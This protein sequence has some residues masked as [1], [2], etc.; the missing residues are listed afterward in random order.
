M[1]TTTLNIHPAAP[2]ADE[3]Q[4]LGRHLRQCREARGRWFATASWVERAHGLIAPRLFTTVL[5]ATALLAL[6]RWWT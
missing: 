2:L 4:A 3:L 5:G 6:C 1:N